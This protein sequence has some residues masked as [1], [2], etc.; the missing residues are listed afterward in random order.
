M[1]IEITLLVL[2][3]FLL[4]SNKFSPVHV[5]LFIFSLLL[6]IAPEPTQLL[7]YSM[8]PVIVSLAA[9]Y[10]VVG[11]LVNTGATQHVAALIMHKPKGPYIPKRILVLTSLLS[12]FINNSPVVAMLTRI[13][14]GHSRRYAI[15]PS[16]WLLPISYA[17]ILGGTC[18]L[19]GTSTNLIVD[20]MM[21]K[22]NGY[23]FHLFE[24]AYVG[25]PLVLVG[26]LYL[27]FVAHKL[28]PVRE[29]SGEQFD[30]VREYMVE[31]L[32]QEGSELD[33][34]TIID[35]GLRSLPGLFL[36]E[37]EREGQV[38]SA[39]R[40]RT[41]L[42]AEDRLIFA[43]SPESVLELRNFRGLVLADDHRFKLE[44]DRGDR[45]LFEAVLSPSNS[46]LGKTIKEARFRHRYSAV[47]LSVCR[48]GARLRGRLGDIELQAGD[49]LLIE[50]QK[51][52]LFRYRNSQDFL[53]VSKFAETDQTD[54]KKANISLSIFSVMIFLS[55]FGFLSIMQASIVAAMS[56]IFTRCINFEDAGKS[57]DYSVLLVIGCAL[58][59]GGAIET[60]GLAGSI[61]ESVLG[62]SSDPFILL[63]GIYLVTVCLTEIISNNA[64]A[65]IM[66]PIAL[67]AASAL[68][69]S[70]QAFAVAVMVAASASFMTPT[71]YQTNLMVMGP[72][73]YKFND[74]LK[75]GAPLSILVALIALTIIP[76]AWPLN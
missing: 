26:W 16:R 69:L 33:G 68:N 52:F 45:R 74:Y 22:A 20:G 8:N 9:L 39:V 51:G 61:A 6:I 41:V 73:G 71:G 76:I 49:T 65:V 17:S 23:E 67:S 37:L 34:K 25:V 38:L 50:A 11:A 28:L 31:M 10:V 58:G 42:N 32:I 30:H 12:A 5:F 46:M 55:G 63:V 2:L 35:A 72:G 60:S 19:I 27:R 62:I 64:A 48:H 29:G 13:V 59:I 53:L 54:T 15:S 47:V 70:P 18:T 40:P 4:V 36:V 3:L 75:V 66:L 21:Q 56:M 57:I 43:G 1:L 44:G 7:S 24:I 14:Q